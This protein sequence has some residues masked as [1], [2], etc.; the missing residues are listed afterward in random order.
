MRLCQGTRAWGAGGTGRCGGWGREPSEVLGRN[1]APG[2]L[3]LCIEWALHDVGPPHRGWA[4]LLAGR[5]AL[6][7]S[8]GGCAGERSV[9]GD[10][11]SFRGVWGQ[12]RME[13]TKA[14]NGALRGPRRPPPLPK[15]TSHPDPGAPECSVPRRPRGCAGSCIS[16]RKGS[17]SAH[18]PRRA[19]AV[20][21]SPART[22]PPGGSA[23]CGPASGRSVHRAVPFCWGPGAPLSCPSPGRP[24]T[25]PSEPP[26]RPAARRG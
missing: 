4:C 19:V 9:S 20:A 11:R 22:A 6:G 10:G 26:G 25:C 2:A 23:S 24:L 21:E 12:A 7:G 16:C 13:G 18:S 1:G 15:P 5:R 17:R 3:G 8:S 14:G